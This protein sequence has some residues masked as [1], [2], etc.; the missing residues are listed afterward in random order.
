MFDE[1]TVID[2]DIELTAIYKDKVPQKP[3]D[4][5]PKTGENNIYDIFAITMIMWAVI[6][7]A[8]MKKTR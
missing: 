7:I 8:I 6:G 2:G 1:E 3:M 4:E 5:T